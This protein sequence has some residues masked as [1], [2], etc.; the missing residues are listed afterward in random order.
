MPLGEIAAGLV[1]SS[2]MAA[3]TTTLLTCLK[4]G[5]AIIAQE[6]LYGATCVSTFMKDSRPNTGSTR[7]S[8][9]TRSRRTGWRPLKLHP[10]A[11]I[12][13]METPSNPGMAVVD[14]KG[15]TEIAHSFGARVIVD[16]TFASPYCQRPLTLGAD[17]VLHSTT[18][19]LSG[20]GQVIGGV[21]VSRIRNLL[22]LNWL[23]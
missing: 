6:Q 1:F 5:D 19:Y 3:I 11:K 14:L 8:F 20:H 12:A 4:N 21:V 9:M 22:A 23:Q 13:Y 7:Y 15:V 16:N 18:K 17:M 10:N 2:G